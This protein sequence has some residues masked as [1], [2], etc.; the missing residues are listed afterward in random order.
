MTTGRTGTGRMKYQMDAL[1]GMALRYH[2]GIADAASTLGNNRPYCYDSNDP[3]H[4]SHHRQASR[5]T[6]EIRLTFPTFRTSR[7]ALFFLSR[8]LRLLAAFAQIAQ[9]E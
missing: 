3:V 4:H 5:V 2:A 6:N 1:N 8:Q 9:A 7:A